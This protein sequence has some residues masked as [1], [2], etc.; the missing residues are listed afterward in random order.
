MIFSSVTFLIYFLPVVI[1]AYYLA[2]AGLKNTVLLAASLFF[3]AWGEPVYIF[4]MIFSII[5]NYTAGIVLGNI[6][7]RVIKKAVLAVFVSVNVLLLG[8][9][10]YADFLISSV[11]EFFGFAAEPLELPLPVGISFYTFQAIS[12]LADVYRKDVSIRKNIIDFAMYISMFPQLIAGPIVRLADIEDS[13]HRRFCSTEMFAAGAKRFTIGLAKKV[14]LANNA[15][16]IW[17]SV[18]A[19]MPGEMSVVS[20]WIGIVGFT[21]QIYFDFSGYSDMA[22][23]LGKMFGF[24]FPENFRY[25]YMSLSVT[26]FWRRWH[27]SLG[28]WFREYVYIPLGGSRAGLLRCA[29]N[30]FVVWFLTRLWHGASMNFVIWGLYFAVLLMAEKLFMLKLLEK[31]PRVAR[32]YTMLVVIV[33]WGVFALDTPD[34]LPYVKTMFGIGSADFFDAQAAYLLEGN[35]VLLVI[36][37]IGST[38]IPHRMYR[39]MSEY[40]ERNRAREMIKLSAENICLAV[41]LITAIAYVEAS[42]YNPFL[43]FRF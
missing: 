10:K 9:F 11:N 16:I 34:I 19:V 13:L 21:F 42:S 37:A 15:G 36:L 40:A 26:E 8:F 30:I 38:E 24:N 6:N 31:V 2:P 18:N 12:Y 1:C 4:L 27:I 35:I 32:I 22:I 41:L 5:F 28:T 29:A 23:G 7:K 17:D 20:S 33:S 25:P 39:I 43:Y 3:Y 14:L